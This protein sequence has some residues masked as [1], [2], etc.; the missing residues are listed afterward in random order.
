M[1]RFTIL[2]F[3]IIC[4]NVLQAQDI[5]KLLLREKNSPDLTIARN[6]IKHH[7][8]WQYKE[9][10]KGVDSQLVE[11]HNYLYNSDSLLVEDDNATIHV[12]EMLTNRPKTENPF[13]S[14]TGLKFIYGY[15]EQGRVVRNRVEYFEPAAQLRSFKSNSGFAYDS[16]GNLTDDM[17]YNVIDSTLIATQHRIYENG[18][19][20]KIIK[21]SQS[22][23]AFMSHLLQYDNNGYLI[24]FNVLG[25]KG[26]NRY[27]FAYSYDIETDTTTQNWIIITAIR[28]KKVYRRYKFFKNG[29]L[30]ELNSYEP[31]SDNNGINVIKEKFFFNP[32]GTMN[33]SIKFVNDVLAVSYKYFYTK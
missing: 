30:T 17:S 7:E 14:F 10:S 2:L 32:D 22:K 24:K 15:D 3:L 8:I 25:P 26:F 23:D 16:L 31:A 19:L 1:Q 11:S 6:H 28:E 29:L 18:R 13:K 27:P 9:G 21:N 4:T 33:T 12:V 20:V 5:V